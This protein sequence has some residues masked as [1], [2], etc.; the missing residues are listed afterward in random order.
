MIINHNIAALNTHRQMGSAQSAQLNSMEK[1]SSG[2]RIN[3]AKDD[4]AGLS[5]SEKMR[6]QIRGLDQASRN[7]QDGISLVQTAE[8]A[9]N[10]THDILQRMRELS[11]Q[12]SNDTNTGDDRNEIQ[13]EIN[14]LNAEVER[15]SGTTEFNTQSLLNGS[16]GAKGTS[17][18]ATKV[19][20][21][22]TTGLNKGTYDV[23]VTQE[24]TKASK[25]A[26]TAA[27]NATV[28]AA[29]G[30][31]LVLNGVKIDTTGV[32]TIEALKTAVNAVKDKTGVEMTVGVAGSAAKFE[33]T[34]FG[35]SGKIDM[36]G[37]D[38]LWLKDKVL[39]TSTNTEPLI[40]AGADA[41][42]EV[43]NNAT[44]VTSALTGVGQQVIYGNAEFSAKGALN[45]VATVTVNS[46]GA[47]IHIGA[48]KD[49]NMLVDINE[50]STNTLGNTTDK[51]K[52]VN[53]LTTEGAEKAVKTVDDA[54]KQVSAERSKL[55]SFQN[56]LEHTINNLKTSSENLTAAESRVRDV[57]YA[58]AA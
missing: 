42:A 41:K 11:V 44:N 50:M 10:E 23:K 12:A 20:V 51:I 47:S 36:A 27:E 19:G 46:T 18:D 9:L 22:S 13:K 49:Q 1:L 37:T 32:T 4:A 16:L 56:R 29:E 17:S 33:A 24:A 5:I 15:I 58:K 30:K 28:A 14:Q 53:V 43:K 8:G 34:T 48:N 52:D 45:S 35:S 57:D 55:G 6:G 31:D 2:M 21:V 39:G 25:T 40:A 26:A 7:A 3:S 54:I 38:A